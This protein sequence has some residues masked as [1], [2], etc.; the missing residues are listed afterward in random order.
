MGYFL[1]TRSNE[2]STHWRPCEYEAMPREFS[3]K[4]IARTALRAAP[5]I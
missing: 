1:R 2:R 3:T 4:P 5:D